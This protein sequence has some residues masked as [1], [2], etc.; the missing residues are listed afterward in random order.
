MS[1]VGLI[2]TGNW[3]SVQNALEH[4]GAEV[5][6]ITDGRPPTHIVIP[7]QGSMRSCMDAIS[8]FRSWLEAMRGCNIPILGI[9]AGMHAMCKH[10]EEGDI[11]GLGWIDLEVWRLPD[12]H[13]PRMGWDDWGGRDYYFCHSYGVG[14]PVIRQENLLG[15]QFH[16]EKSQQAGLDFLREFL[17]WRP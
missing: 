5:S 15:C 17:E 7:G 16:P 4:L 3:R 12:K 9:C 2:R 8:P 6:D 10:S 13:L 11:D 14:S 1:V